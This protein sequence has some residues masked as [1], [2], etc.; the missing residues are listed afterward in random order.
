MGLFARRKSS[1]QRPLFDENQS[2]TPQLYS[3]LS[4]NGVLFNFEQKESFND[5]TARTNNSTNKKSRSLRSLQKKVDRPT[6]GH[7]NLSLVPT[8]KPKTKKQNERSPSAASR[9]F[10]SNGQPISSTGELISPVRQHTAMSLPNDVSDRNLRSI[11][12]L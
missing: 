9:V 6:T 5:G 1:F 4:E 11:A 3:P 8:L 10:F 2:Y 7:S 12:S